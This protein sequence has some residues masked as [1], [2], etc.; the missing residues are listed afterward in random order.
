MDSF[1]GGAV[2]DGR[3]PYLETLTITT[4]LAANEKMLTKLQGLTSRIVTD[5]FIHVHDLIQYLG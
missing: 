2:L 4:L 3:R 5:G 1:R